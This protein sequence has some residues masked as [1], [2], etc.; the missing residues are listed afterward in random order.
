MPIHHSEKNISLKQVDEILEY[1]LH[2]VKATYEFYLR[3]TDKIELRKKLSQLYNINLI[4]SDDVKIGET[5]F[6]ELLS[7]EMNLNKWDLRKLRT[8]RESINLADIILPYIEFNTKPFKELLHAFKSTIV[9]NTKDAFKF[10]MIDSG[11][12]YLYGQGGI[13][14]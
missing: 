7:K 4:N 8:I 11:M 9:R 10:N 3:S 5:I 2:D 6:L 14:S 1:N 12:K 13:H